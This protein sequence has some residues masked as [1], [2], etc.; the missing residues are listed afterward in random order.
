MGEAR[1]RAKALE[2]HRDELERQIDLTAVGPS[3]DCALRRQFVS[4][5]AEVKR[6]S[7]SK[8]AI[9]PSLDAVAQARAYAAGGASGVSVLTEPAHFGGSTEDLLAIRQSVSLPALKKDFHVADIQL[10]EARALGAS[11][12]L[13]IVRALSPE[14]L[15][16][17]VRYGLGLGLELLVEVRDDEELVRALD[18]GATMIGVNNRDLETLIIDPTTAERVIPKIPSSL[19]AIAESGVRSRED[20]ER[21]AAIGADA[22]LVGSSLSASANPVMATSALAGVARRHRAG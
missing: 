15:T 3:L 1:L 17:L 14:L 4:L 5:L 9:A 8:G 7:P 10:L 19:V 2:T 13:L 6:Q 12:A 11:A 20:V 18:A 21:Y 22:V 16:R